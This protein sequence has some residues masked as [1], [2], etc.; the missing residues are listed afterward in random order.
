MARRET[1][2]DEVE[3]LVRKGKNGRGGGKGRGR[4]GRSSVKMMPI[5]CRGRGRR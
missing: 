1:G 3:D 4:S 5:G 2:K